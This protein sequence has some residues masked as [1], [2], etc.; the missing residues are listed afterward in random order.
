MLAID[1]KGDLGNLLL[2]FE[3]PG[4]GSF[5]PWID[6]EAARREGRT[7]RAAAAEAAAAWKKG[8]AEWGLG[9]ADVAALARAPRGRHLH[10]GLDGRACR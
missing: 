9:A 7:S 8:L 6:A 2:L 1:P 4:A 10:A 5:A 3:R